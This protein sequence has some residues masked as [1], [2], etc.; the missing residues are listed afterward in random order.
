MDGDTVG[1]DNCGIAGDGYE[2]KAI[3]GGGMKVS[4]C[5]G[6]GGISGPSEPPTA[7]N[8]DATVLASAAVTEY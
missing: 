4:G 1:A 8:A 7:W 2:G 6:G 3:A 5:G